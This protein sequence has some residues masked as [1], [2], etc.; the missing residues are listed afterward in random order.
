MVCTG[1]S[2]VSVLTRH[3]TRRF[4]LFAGGEGESAHE[5]VSG[6]GFFMLTGS[7]RGTEVRGGRSAVITGVLSA[8]RCDASPQE[9][10]G[11]GGGSKAAG[12]DFDSPAWGPIGPAAKYSGWKILGK[13]QMPQERNMLKEVITASTFTADCNFQRP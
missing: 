3:K 9:S 12:R 8:Q 11:G 1:A 2:V 7:S 13:K 5:G 10:G 6:G 4:C